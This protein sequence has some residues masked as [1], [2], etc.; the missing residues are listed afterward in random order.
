MDV[1][2]FSHHGSARQE[3]WLYRFLHPRVALIGVGAD[4]DYGHPAP[5]AL[6]MLTRIGAV[7]F[8]TDTQGQIAV[9]GG[10]DHLRVV[11]AR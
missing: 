8:R 1:V 3:E 4:N 11:T 7:A 2:V 5:A 10:P 9:T 6:G